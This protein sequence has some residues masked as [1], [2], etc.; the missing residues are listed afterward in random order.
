MTNTNTTTTKATNPKDA[1]GCTK[2]PLS[3]IPMPP[4][5]EVGAALLE[6]ACKYRRHNYREAGV[7]SSIYFDAA[8]RHL[9][10]WWEGQDIDPDSGI[11]HIS[12]AIAGLFVLRDSQMRGNVQD[13][14]PPG[15]DREPNRIDWLQI[16]QEQTDKV[17]ARYPEPLPP[18]TNGDDPKRAETRIAISCLAVGDTFWDAWGNRY[19]VGEIDLEKALVFATNGD[20]DRDAFAFDQLVEAI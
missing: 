19:V 13:D 2:P 8:M 1:I 12:K 14:R 17:L 3:T 18:C 15:F 7:R 20:G 4:L 10:A 16:A 5:F 9:A 11:H 6:G